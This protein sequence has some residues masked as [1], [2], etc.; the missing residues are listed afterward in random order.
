[1]LLLNL[2]RLYRTIRPL[3]PSQ[4]FGR[5][6]F[7]LKKPR[8]HQALLPE[9]TVARNEFVFPELGSKATYKNDTFQFL[10]KTGRLSEV[11]WL[12]ESRSKLWRYNQHYFDY[13]N[14]ADSDQRSEELQSLIEHWLE[15]N[16]PFEGV[17]WE[18]Y[19]TSLRIVNW[20]KWQLRGYTLTDA[21]LKSLV[22][23]IRWLERR[24][25][26]HLLGNHLIANAKAL[27]FSGYFF[28][29]VEA[30]RWRN[31]GLIILANELREQILEDGAHFELSP[32]YHAIILQD[33]LD[34][35]NIKRAYNHKVQASFKPRLCDLEK[36]ASKMLTWL[37]AVSH[38][39]G[40]I[41]FFN[42]AA[43]G[44]SPSNSALIAYAG[45]F[46]IKY[47][48]ELQGLSDL[49]A[50]GYVRME[51]S[52][53]VVLADLAEIGPTYL[54]GHAHAD[55]L[56]FELSIHG[57]RII[58]NSGTSEYDSGVER[59]R[60]RGTSAHNT[61]SIDGQDSSE[62]WSSFRV[63]SRANVFNR[64]FENR[65]GILRVSGTHNGFEKRGIG[66]AHTREFTLSR[67]ELTI[68][69]SLSWSSAAEVHYYFHPDC[70][71]N[72]L[73]KS[74]GTI[75]LVDSSELHWKVENAENVLIKET[76]WHPYFGVSI[77]NSCLVLK[78][79]GTWCTFNLTWDN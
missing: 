20:I 15:N 32:M 36:L 26:R 6:L 19:P 68:A 27:V 49:S 17:G 53:C 10:N 4:T 66:P 79:S 30:N 14:T 48:N 39:D 61:L 47:N 43:F 75:K 12:N 5:V 11:G 9:V 25:E 51:L 73:T 42:D 59:L 56:S 1:M 29:G 72:L 38:P 2:L 74:A 62:V 57:K 78:V 50:S 76:T 71:I 16:P 64:K 37:V 40:G 31:T 33:I 21:A 52:N 22:L 55:S 63:G 67:G 65:S 28:D 60:Q 13:L 58:V 35:I 70:K 54:P 24:L 23:Q 34:L 18:P 44:V 45:R 77:K 69:D 8:I 46:G 41:S 3:R 7:K